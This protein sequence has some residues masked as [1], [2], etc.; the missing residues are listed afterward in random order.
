MNR[1][2]AETVFNYLKPESSE[3]ML[4]EQP[5]SAGMG[6]LFGEVDDSTTT[7]AGSLAIHG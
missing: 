2:S 3:E 6:A 5:A 4:E 7:H 1:V